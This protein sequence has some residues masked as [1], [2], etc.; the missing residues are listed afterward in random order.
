MVCSIPLGLHHSIGMLILEVAIGLVGPGWA[1]PT[2]GQ[3]KT[4]PGQNWP[5]FLG[6]KF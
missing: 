3:A 5:G 4:G 6:P 2:V 1:G